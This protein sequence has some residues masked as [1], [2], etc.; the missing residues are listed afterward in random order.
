MSIVLPQ[1]LAQ[2][3]Y[4]FSEGEHIQMPSC[5]EAEQIAD[6]RQTCAQTGEYKKDQSR[7]LQGW[8]NRRVSRALVV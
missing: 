7:L 8:L 4:W 5:L 1:G 6:K 3:E 2:H